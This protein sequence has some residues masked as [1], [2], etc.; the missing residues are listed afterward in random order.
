MTTTPYATLLSVR[1]VEEQEAEVALAEALRLAA[2]AERGLLQLRRAREAWLDEGMDAGAL[3][4]VESAEREA[5]TRLA[6]ARTAADR[7]RDTLIERQRQRKLV[8][9]LH[10]DTLTAQAQA[11]AR[12]AQ[13]ELDELGSRSASAFTE[14]GR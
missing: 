11:E 4:A 5:E 9:Q 2:A 3:A 14:A 7:A 8:E 6:A 1:R 10:V 13:K 12:R